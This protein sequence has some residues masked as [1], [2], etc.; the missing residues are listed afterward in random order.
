[1]QGNETENPFKFVYSKLAT[2]LWTL[3]IE[4]LCSYIKVNVHAFQ[5]L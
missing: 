3:D 4:N 5:D 1:M 2:L